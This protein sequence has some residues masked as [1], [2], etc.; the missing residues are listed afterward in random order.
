MSDLTPPLWF[1]VF[2]V[3][4][5][6]VSLTLGAAV[7][8]TPAGGTHEVRFLQYGVSLILFI[9]PWWIPWSLFLA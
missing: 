6:Q 4:G 5:P 8:R 3:A 9:I 1:A 7:V 2:G